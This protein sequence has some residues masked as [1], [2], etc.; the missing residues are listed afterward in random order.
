MTLAPDLR[1][2]PRA[3]EHPLVG[4]FARLA[5]LAA[6]MEL[7]LGLPEGD[8]AERARWVRCAD[9]LAEPARFG[10][11]RARLGEWLVA[12][13]DV[14]EAPERTTAGY[15]LAWY[16]Q[17]PALLGATL[18]HTERRVPS[19][20][21][22]D[23]A[24]RLAEGRPHP[25]GIAL[26]DRGFACLPD[27]PAAG[28]PGS[29]VVA[30]EQALAA[31]LRARYVGHAARFV[32]AFGPTVRFGRRML[33]AAATDALD[34]SAWLAGRVLHDEGGGVANAA[35]LLPEAVAPLTSG[36]TLCAV[37]D[38]SGRTAWTRRRESCC[39]HY[40]LPGAEACVT[41]PRVTDEER[42]RRVLD[43]A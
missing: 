42:A 31:L 39:F 35:L 40:V 25:D 10:E 41:C 12:H 21:P 4:A 9:L 24:F 26:L 32:A 14:S 29:T 6:M 28:V 8:A 7:R 16:L 33:W 11:W 5:P 36:S 3:P 19:L 23:L 13:H 30:D 18:F 15:V 27:D 2:P 17:V 1:V 22:E 43:E 38:A 20:R 34:N 37:T